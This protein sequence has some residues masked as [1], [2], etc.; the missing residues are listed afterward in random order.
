[1]TAAIVA[2]SWLAGARVG[3]WLMDKIFE[4]MDRKAEERALSARNI[5]P[6][7]R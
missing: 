2:L 1:M 5:T 4:H 6:G 7:V 3:W